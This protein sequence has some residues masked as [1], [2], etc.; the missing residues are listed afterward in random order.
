MAEVR[1]EY[2]PG[3]AVTETAAGA[4]FGFP[5]LSISRTFLFVGRFLVTG[6]G[7]ACRDTQG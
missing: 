5:S 6:E 1:T 2:S 7:Q 4:C 3:P